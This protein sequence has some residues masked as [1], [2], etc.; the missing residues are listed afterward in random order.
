[1]HA[2]DARSR[3]YT[4]VVVAG[5]AVLVVIAPPTWT[6]IVHVAAKNAQ[7]GIVAQLYP[8]MVHGMS[9]CGLLTL[10]IGTAERWREWPWRQGVMLLLGFGGAAV[11]Y[12]F[13]GASAWERYL[14]AVFPVLIM[15]MFILAVVMDAASRGKDRAAA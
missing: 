10:Y 5:F 1:M 7:H 6:E 8:M 4:A 14:L 3:V 9:L 13:S 2:E 12:F 11:M 15:T